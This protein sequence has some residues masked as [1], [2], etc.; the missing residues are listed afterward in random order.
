MLMERRQG[1]S[2]LTLLDYSV[3]N[4]KH[5]NKINRAGRMLGCSDVCPGSPGKIGVQ[6]DMCP[7]DF[8]LGK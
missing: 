1:D 8:C 6:V 2:R 7:V 4:D 3:A 5:L